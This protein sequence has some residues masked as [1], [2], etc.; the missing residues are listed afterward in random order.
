MKELA[1]CFL[2]VCNYDVGPFGIAAHRTKISLN[3]TIAHHD[4]DELAEAGPGLQTGDGLCVYVE[5]WTVARVDDHLFDRQRVG[6]RAQGTGRLTA[7][8]VRGHALDHVLREAPGEKNQR[9]PEAN[10]GGR[11]ERRAMVTLVAD[12]VG[13]VLK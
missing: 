9:P 11:D 13:L 7:V 5:V 10:L 2:N 8:C 4:F 1:W 12:P 3:Q 6:D